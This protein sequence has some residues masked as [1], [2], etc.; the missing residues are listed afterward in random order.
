MGVQ[1]NRIS[2]SVNV[3]G[4]STLQKVTQPILHEDISGVDN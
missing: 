1:T 3:P 4:S 2:S